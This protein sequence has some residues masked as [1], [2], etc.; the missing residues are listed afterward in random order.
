MKQNV[1]NTDRIVRLVLAAAL[2]LVAGL[3]GFGSVAGIILII[4]AVVAAGT[5]AVSLCPI[6][7]ALGLSTKR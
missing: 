1:G 3:V 7:L 4:V 2:L 5:S 6:Y